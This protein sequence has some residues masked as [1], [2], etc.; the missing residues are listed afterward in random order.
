MGGPP[1]DNTAIDEEGTVT[2]VRLVGYSVLIG[3][4]L[5]YFCF[6]SVKITIMV[7]IVG[8]TSAMLSMAMVWWTGG[9][10]DAILMSMPSLVYVLGLSG[11]IHVINYYRDEV[12]ERGQARCAWPSASPRNAALHAGLGDHR[13]RSGIAVHQ[14]PGA[15]Q[16]LWALFG[17]RRD[18]DARHSV[19]VFAGVA[20]DVFSDFR[21]DQDDSQA[22]SPHPPSR[23]SD[24]WASVGRWITGHHALVSLAFLVVLVVASAGLR[25][26]QTSVQLLKL[27]DAESRIIHDYS[28][29]ETHF[30]KLVPMELI[31]R[32]PPAM[33]R[34][35][36]A[37]RLRQVPGKRRR[38]RHSPVQSLEMLERVELV[39]RIRTVVD[40]TL[41][42]PG[43]GSSGKR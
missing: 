40:R 8:G 7:F 13:D 30:G 22:E 24:W 15:D 12:R 14:Q 18:H 39:S 38:R 21:R 4:V 16:Q 25:N 43:A 1:V 19:F 6:R 41:G 2:L 29:L 35:S 31:V 34:S 33:Q 42:E 9:R 5:S 26:I 32:V 37:R 10:V 28:W 23:L 27:F 3:I 20:A 36:Q 11:A 17:H